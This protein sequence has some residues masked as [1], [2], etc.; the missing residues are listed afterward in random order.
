MYL[1]VVSQKL[2]CLCLVDSISVPGTDGHSNLVNHAPIV[3]TLREGIVKIH[4]NSKFIF[5]KIVCTKK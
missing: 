2:F 1:E 3:S 4:L 5:T